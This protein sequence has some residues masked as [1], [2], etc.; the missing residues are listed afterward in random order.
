MVFFVRETI[1]I[2]ISFE[3]QRINMP[4]VVESQSKKLPGKTRREFFA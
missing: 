1:F 2:V 4:A 3:E